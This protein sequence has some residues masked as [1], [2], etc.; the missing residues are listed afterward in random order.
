MKRTK[1]YGR[2]AVRYVL[3]VYHFAGSLD[4]LWFYARKRTC[5][6][7]GHP[8]SVGNNAEPALSSP[9][10]R[11]PKV[12]RRRKREYYRKHAQHMKD[13]RNNETPRER[14]QTCR[15]NG[16]PEPKSFVSR[17]NLYTNV[18]F[19]DND[20]LASQQL[21]LRWKHGNTTSTTRH[22]LVIWI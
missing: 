11:Q 18:S 1:L 5:R 8:M 20:V 4:G 12:R 14:T 17:K 15:E 10:P 9:P 3:V 2:E 13:K 21:A 6:Q 19:S 16:E 22:G 7:L